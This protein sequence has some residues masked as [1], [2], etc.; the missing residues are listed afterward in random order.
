MKEKQKIKLVV[1]NAVKEDTKTPASKNRTVTNPI[2]GRYLEFTSKKT[3]KKITLR[4]FLNEL[5]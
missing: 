5:F 4:D 3:K 2:Y 1:N